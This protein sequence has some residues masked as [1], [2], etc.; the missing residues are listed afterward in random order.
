[1]SFFEDPINQLLIAQLKQHGVQLA[2]AENTLEQ[3]SS[4]LAEKTIVIS[5]VFAYHSRE[6]YKSLIT[7]HGGKEAS[8]ISSK[9][10][11]L[12]AGEQAGPSKLSKA[13]SLAVPIIDETE[14]LKMIEETSDEKPSR[15]QST[16][17]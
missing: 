12:L 16:L 9:T 8:G 6:E 15:Q 7:E 1:V 10:S 14:F 3:K 11:F 13:K 5:G 2:M 17:F 4:R